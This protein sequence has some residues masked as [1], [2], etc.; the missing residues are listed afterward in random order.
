M[1][2]QGLYKELKSALASNIFYILT[3]PLSL[4]LLTFQDK[5]AIRTTNVQIFIIKQGAVVLKS[6]TFV[7]Q[8]SRDKHVS[9]T[10]VYVKDISHAKIFLAH[11]YVWLLQDR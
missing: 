2:Q 8:D 7:G 4:L 9:G 5:N 1:K 11:I 6:I 3:G 10:P